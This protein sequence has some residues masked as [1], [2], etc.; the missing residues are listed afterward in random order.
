M[1]GSVCQ[2]DIVV[3]DGNW[4]KSILLDIY[5]S[6]FAPSKTIDRPDELKMVQRYQQPFLA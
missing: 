6:E 5:G 3:V 4:E 1:E 2:L